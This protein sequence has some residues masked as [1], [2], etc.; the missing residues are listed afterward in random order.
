MSSILDAVSIVLVCKD[1]IF[2]IKRQNFLRAFPGYWAFPGG[3]VDEVDAD[4]KDT[5]PLINNIPPKLWGAIRREAQEEL[6]VDLYDLLNT[7]TIT[8]LKSIGMAL[9][10][11][12]N[13][14][15][16]RTYFY[17]IHLKEKPS[18]TV[19]TNE[20][21]IAQW[22]KPEDFIAKY[23]AGEML[24][25]PPVLRVV[26]LLAQNPFCSQEKLDLEYDPSLEVPMIE[27]I[28]GVRQYMPL[29]H[30]LPPANRTNALVIGD[31]VIDPSPKD[32]NELEKLLYSIRDEELKAVFLTH[33]HVDHHQFAPDLARKRNLPIYLSADTQMRI[34]AQR[35]DYFSRLTLLRAQDTQVVTKWLGQDVRVVEVPGHDKGQL[36]LMPQSRSWFLAGDLFQGVGTVVI[37]GSEGD[38]AEYLKTLERVI[39]LSPEAVIPSHGIALGGVTILERTLT[40][41]KMREAQIIDLLK[42]QKNEDEILVILYSDVDQRLL[43]YARENIRSHILKI[44]RENLT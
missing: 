27:T 31:L 35:P 29:S 7:G 22:M 2:P 12:F 4:S 3:K 6:G 37:G 13:P 15:R 14:Y 24:V 33:H 9:T 20:A 16:F 18:F 10:P 39:N 5:H 34:E 32:E 19:D 30:T 42:G 8:D 44:K 41:R 25:V 28:C 23:Q 40:H 21:E 1:E 11:D 17:G 43:K 26:K 36:A 38:M